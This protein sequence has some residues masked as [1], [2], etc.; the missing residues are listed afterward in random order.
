LSCAFV[1]CVGLVHFL[2]LNIGKRSVQG[3]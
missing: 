1:M 2:I 3:S